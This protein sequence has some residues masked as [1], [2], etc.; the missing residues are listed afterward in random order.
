MHSPSFGFADGFEYGAPADRPSR[1]SWRRITKTRVPGH[2]D[3]RRRGPARSSPRRRPDRRP[4]RIGGCTPPRGPRCRSPG[5]GRSPSPARPPPIAR[6]APRRPGPARAG[7]GPQA[8]AIR[9]SA[10]SAQSTYAGWVRV[11]NNPI[12]PYQAWN[13][14]ECSA[15]SAGSQLGRTTSTSPATSNTSRA[16]RSSGAARVGLIS[17]ADTWTHFWVASATSPRGP[18]I[19]TCRSDIMSRLNVEPQVLARRSSPNSVGSWWRTVMPR[20]MNAQLVSRYRWGI[21]PRRDEPSTAASWNSRQR[22]AGPGP[23]AGVERVALELERDFLNDIGRAGPR[24][25]P[26]HSRPVPVRASAPVPFPT[27]GATVERVGSVRIFRFR[28]A[29]L[30]GR[31]RANQ[32]LRLSRR[33]PGAGT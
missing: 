2:R 1:D 8:A 5:S 25:Q 28:L 7:R 20:T 6:T 29:S 26:P 22:I 27:R 10:S 3:R 9:A 14:N 31:G 30:I 32:R 15:P 19:R 33:R 16:D 4:P 17:G 12:Q 11:A 13:A 23:V 18:T 24:A 21:H